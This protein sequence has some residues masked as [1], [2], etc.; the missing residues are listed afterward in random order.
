MH[1]LCT[2]TV[3]RQRHAAAVPTSFQTFHPESVVVGRPPAR[4]AGHP[5]VRRRPL[6][7][8]LSSAGAKDWNADTDKPGARTR[9]GMRRGAAAASSRALEPRVAPTDM[10]F[11]SAAGK[12]REPT[13]AHQPAAA[14]ADDC[15]VSGFK[16]DRT[17]APSASIRALLFPNPRS[18]HPPVSSNIRC[19]R[20]LSRGANF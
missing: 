17:P 5:P 1:I 15:I 10:R 14:A 9:R 12:R 16:R 6:S 2:V 13:D 3:S 7:G 18:K 4:P 19:T 11:G 8:G 20:C